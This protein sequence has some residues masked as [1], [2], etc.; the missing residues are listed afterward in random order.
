[1]QSP[2]L[3]RYS[4]LLLT[5]AVGLD[6]LVTRLGYPYVGKA[7]SSIMVMFYLL[8]FISLRKAVVSF[9][10]AV[11]D[12]FFKEISVGGERRRPSSFVSST[13]QLC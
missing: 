5:S 2:T 11:M 4:F 9:W 12:I 13:R 6:L 7:M 3:H 10:N 8:D 1:M